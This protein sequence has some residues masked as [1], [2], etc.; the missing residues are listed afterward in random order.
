MTLFLPTIERGRTFSVQH[1]ALRGSA[2]KFF[3]IFFLNP[4]GLHPDKNRM[5]RKYHAC[6][7]AATNISKQK[8]LPEMGFECVE[9][10]T[11]HGREK[12][13]GAGSFPLI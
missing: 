11:Q 12:V 13:D 4:A 5:P 1:F 9:K 10:P 7:A 2:D 8:N 6:H 3:V